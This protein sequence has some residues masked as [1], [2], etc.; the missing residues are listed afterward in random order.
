[1]KKTE[2][3][4]QIYNSE[5]DLIIKQSSILLQKRSD[6]FSGELKTSGAI[7]ENY[8]KGIINKHIPSGY[9]VCSGY[10]ATTETIFNTENL[11]QHDIII[12][13]EKIPSLYKFDVSDIEII[14]AE[15]VC[16]IIEIKRT[17]NKKTLKDATE[18]LHK[19]KVILDKYKNGIKSKISQHNNNQLSKPK[20]SFSPIYAIISLQSEKEKLN[21]QY[22]FRY[23]LK[24]C[25]EFID[26]IWSLSDG[27]LLTFLKNKN[28]VNHI[29]ENT[30]REKK[31]KEEYKINFNNVEQENFGQVFHM[32]ITALR[33]WITNTYGI[34]LDSRTNMEYFGTLNESSQPGGS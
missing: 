9:R 23:V 25:S 32:G 22:V 14:P 13:D 4:Q 33:I 17:L 16:G 3:I 21:K 19:T 26:L 5:I 31:F 8:V 24:D 18:H 12:V 7:V 34:P 27:L 6:G 28:G 15:A 30:G 20:E 29:P 10:I 11:S 1:M 2:S